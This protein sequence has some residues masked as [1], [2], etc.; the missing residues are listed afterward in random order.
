MG[1][2][3]E[4]YADEIIHELEK[5]KHGAWVD[6]IDKCSKDVVIEICQNVIEDWCGR[7]IDHVQPCP[8]EPKEQQ[9]AEDCI[10]R[11]E[12]LKHTHIEYDDDGIG[13]RVVY[14]ED[15][16]ELPSVTPSIPEVEDNFDI[17]YNCGYAD[18]MCDIGGES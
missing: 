8:K 11:Q 16:E 15:I 6:W 17:G 1:K 10:S 2:M 9:T 14:A 3:K 18:A 13:H 7:S 4:K 5:I 12:A